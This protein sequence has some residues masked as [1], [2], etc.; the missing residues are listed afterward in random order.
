VSQ[1]IYAGIEPQD[2]ER[3]V[4][5]FMSVAKVF[6]NRAWQVFWHFLFRCFIL[7]GLPLLGWGLDD[8]TGF[9][10]D[11]VR[12]SFV[13][14]A[15]VLALINAWLIYGKPLPPQP[16]DR[17]EPYHSFFD[18]VE[19]I[20]FLAAFGAR[21]D[22]LTWNAGP[23]VGWVG[24][25]IYLAGSGLSIWSN[26]IWVS[27]LRREGE[28]ACGSPAL[29]CEGPFHWIRYPGLLCI[30]FYGLGF[31]IMFQ[32]WL[33]LALMIPLMSIVIRRVKILE[34]ENAAEY[35]KD[36]PARC[37]TSTRLVPFIY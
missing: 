5:E 19:M 32:S 25:G 29:L 1:G 23:L 35:P 10:A 16:H 14:V 26:F 17:F 24:L 31:S 27:H 28:R 7:I 13:V 9:F 12:A 21:R 34:Q 15:T 30:F 3:K 6:E 36:W 37:Q 4:V 20:F 8:V 11:P 22:I 33:G 2:A 18:I